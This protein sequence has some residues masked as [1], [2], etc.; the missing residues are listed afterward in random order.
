MILST[1]SYRFVSC[2][3]SYICRHIWRTG[4]PLPRTGRPVPLQRAEKY[5]LQVAVLLSDVAVKTVDRLLK[6]STVSF[7]DS[8][9]KLC[10]WATYK[11]IKFYFA[12]SKKDNERFWFS[13]SKNLT[14]LFLSSLDYSLTSLCILFQ[15]RNQK[16]F[17]A[18]HYQILKVFLS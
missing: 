6:R 3:K 7:A 14:K 11:R 9:I 8:N 10:F 2:L 15:E 16:H 13:L 12:H 17:W 1:F 18:N 5:P 4:R